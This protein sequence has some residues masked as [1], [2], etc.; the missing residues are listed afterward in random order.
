MATRRKTERL[1]SSSTARID[2]SGRLE[3]LNWTVRVVSG[4]D[5]GSARALAG[6]MI[7]GSGD[8]ANFKLKDTAVSHH[9]LELQPRADGVFVRDLGS[10]NG[11]LLAGARIDTAFVE[12]QAVISLGRTLLAVSVVAEEQELDGA[13]ELEGLVGTG[14]AMR[15]VFGLVEKL[16]RANTPVLFLGEQGTGKA[17]LASALHARSGRKGALITVD[18]TSSQVESALFERGFEEAEGGTLFLDELGALP[19]ELQPRLLRALEGHAG[20]DVRVVAASSRALE[21]EVKAGKFRNDLYLRVAVAAVRVPPL[22]ERKE[23]LPALVRSM[24]VELGR[25]SFE[26]SAGLTSTLAG[27]SWPG[28]VR[29]LRTVVARAVVSDEVSVESV[30]NPG[31]Q[32][33]SS[34]PPSLDVPFKEAKERLVETFTREYLVALSAKHEGNVTQMAKASG[35]ARTY[36]HDLLSRYSL[37]RSSQR[38]EEE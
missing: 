31:P 19:L 34:E 10:T 18:C 20:G 14:A 2:A 9:H 25:G 17:R 13:D 16:A 35:L 12:A 37:S 8:D 11:T 6:P 22:R 24:L 26:L 32:T 27:Y 3:V 28:N 21:T 36:L 1:G 33:R 30:L 4:P 29:E 7:V 38:A 23:D 15:R 5:A